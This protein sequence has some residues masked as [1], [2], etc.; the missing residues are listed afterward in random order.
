MLPKW[1]MVMHVSCLDLTEHANKREWVGEMH[2]SAQGIVMFCE[3]LL[4]FLFES[5]FRSA[6][7][8]QK[9]FLKLCE[10]KAVTSVPVPKRLAAPPLFHTYYYFGTVA[11]FVHSSIIMSQCSLGGLGCPRITK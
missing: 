6:A 8:G 10:P 11:A 2:I 4:Q 1:E 5:V 3:I 7:V 9:H